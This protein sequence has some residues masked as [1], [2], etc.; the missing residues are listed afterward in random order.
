[1]KNNHPYVFLDFFKKHVKDSNILQYIQRNVKIIIK[2]NNILNEFFP[3]EMKSFY[4][5]ANYRNNTIFIEVSNANLLT[6]FN[7]EK[8]KIF[9]KLKKNILPTL[10]LIIIKINPNLVQ[11]NK[12]NYLNNNQNIFFNRKIEKYRRQI[13]KKT[14]NELLIL[15]QKSS[16]KLKKSLEKLAS[17]S[18]DKIFF[19]KN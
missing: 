10:S 6:R 2:L 3:T 15:S 12:Q 19:K 9:F 5:V 7:Y 4:R 13:S 18:M 17:H 1:M 16:E 8:R 14:A 11:K